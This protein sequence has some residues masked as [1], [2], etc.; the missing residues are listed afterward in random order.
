MYGTASQ[1]WGPGVKSNMA[2]IEN[3]IRFTKYICISLEI[4]VHIQKLH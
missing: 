1:Y 4:H 2:D 3:Y